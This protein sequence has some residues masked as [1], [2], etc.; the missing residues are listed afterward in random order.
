[1]YMNINV[2]RFQFLKCVVEIHQTT[3]HIL[4]TILNSKGEMLVDPVISTIITVDYLQIGHV[5]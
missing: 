5:R 3:P 2:Y 4:P 1:M